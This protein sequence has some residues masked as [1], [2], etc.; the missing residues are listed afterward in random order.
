MK[1]NT[2][3]IH[4]LFAEIICQIQ[5][6]RNIQEKNKQPTCTQNSSKNKQKNIS[7][8]T[9]KL[10]KRQKQRESHNNKP[11]SARFTNIYV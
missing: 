10:Q 8:Y 11:Y 2:K 7:A 5:K 4:E 6:K 1:L 3:Y 9:V